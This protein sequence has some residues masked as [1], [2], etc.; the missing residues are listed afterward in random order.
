MTEVVAAELVI[1]VQLKG[2]FAAGQ[3][4]HSAITRIKRR[5]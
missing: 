4:L 5:T 1:Y 3:V 2:T